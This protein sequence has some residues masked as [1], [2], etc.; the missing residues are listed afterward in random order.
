M[1][2]QLPSRP[3]TAA[4]QQGGAPSVRRDLA[5]M[6]VFAR[7]NGI[8]GELRAL[9][10]P[11]LTRVLCAAALDWLFIMLATAAVITFGWIAV[12][13]ALLVIGN[14]QRALGNLLHDASHRS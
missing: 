10:R 7:A 6:W 9:H 3:D 4:T 1:S 12:A 8:A 2:K 5:E 14:R 13:P 11:V